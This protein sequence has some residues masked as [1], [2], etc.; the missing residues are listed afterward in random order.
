V[1]ILAYTGL[2]GSGK[3]YSVVEH[4]VLPALKAGRRVATNIALNE[5]AILED[6]PNGELVTFDVMELQGQPEKVFDYCTPGTVFI[7]DEVWRLFPSGQRADKVP[8]PFRKLL[9][10]HRHMVNVKGESCQIVLVTQDLAQIAAFARQ[11]VEQTFRTTKL[12]IVGL[13]KSFRVDVFNGPISGPNPSLQTRIRE[14]Y[15]KYKPAVFRYYKSHTMSEAATEGADE[16]KVDRRGNLLKSKAFIILAIVVLAL[17]WWGIKRTAGYLGV[18][19]SPATASAS[20]QGPAAAPEAQQRTGTFAVPV[21]QS[22]IPPEPTVR[23]CI[24]VDQ[25]GACWVSDGFATWSVPLSACSLVPDGLS[26]SYA[27]ADAG[28]TFQPHRLGAGRR[29]AEAAAQPSQSGS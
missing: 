1:S 5:S 16:R 17:A 28:R 29:P 21:R 2:P 6:Y 25:A 23:G 27:C 19:D 20:V 9:A 22:D 24:E 7:L 18:G 26:R 14:I 3:S 8:E 10:E 13:N 4:Q 12:G 15:G 11:L